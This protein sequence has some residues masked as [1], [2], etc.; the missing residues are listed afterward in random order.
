MI[1]CLNVP[2]LKDA[3]IRAGLN[4]SGLAKSLD[5]SRE[6]VS[7]W[8]KGE[9]FPQPDKLLRIGVLVGLTF[10]E[11]VSGPTPTAVPIVTY[12]KKGSR[13]TKDLH[14]DNARETGELLK[15]LV[16]YLPERELTQPPTLKT[17]TDEYHY[18]QRVAAEVRIEMGLEGKGVIDFTDLIGKFSRLQAVLIPVLWGAKERHGNA[19][20]IHLP[21]SRTTWGFLNLDSNVV[22]FKFWMAH[23]L[24]HCLAPTLGGEAGEDF[25]EAFAQALLFPEPYAK[26]LRDDLQTVQG[27]G[28][29]VQRI[30]EEAR[31]HI[32]SPYTIRLAIE[33]YEL[34]GE[35]P[36]T[37]MG[38][39]GPFMGGVKNFCK[40][41]KT[42]SEMLFKATPPTP[43]DYIPVARSAFESPF[44]ETLA[45]FVRH[46]QGAEHFI[47]CVLGVSL[48]DAKAL[49]GE[50]QA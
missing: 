26:K 19:L 3:L 9:T 15:R 21:N 14:L 31:K 29:R 16:A 12:R 44:F 7:K 11:L 10:D 18:V 8:F 49:S 6:A 36:R 13:K 17:P 24:G 23:E 41:Y 33:T 43:S 34:A 47:H 32:I 40:G 42:V 1:R 5:V 4:Q 39:L 50:L 38:T 37:N 25:A 35:E 27:V 48:A 28:A 45:E 2:I 46:E 20:N 30:R 22:D